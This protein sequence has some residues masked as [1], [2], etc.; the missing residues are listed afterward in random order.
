MN[1]NTKK[2]YLNGKKLKKV[3]VYLNCDCRDSIILNL[4]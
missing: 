3:Y 2:K 4:S 1:E